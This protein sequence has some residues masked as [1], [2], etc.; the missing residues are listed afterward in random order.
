MSETHYELDP[1]NACSLLNLASQGPMTLQQ[2][3][4][5]VRAWADGN[6]GSKKARNEREIVLV[7]LGLALRAERGTPHPFDVWTKD[8][9]GA[10]HPTMDCQTCGEWMGHGHE[11]EKS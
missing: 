5:R 2:F 1:T 4:A 7:A 9:A 8:L 10:S 11:C 6:G 3:E